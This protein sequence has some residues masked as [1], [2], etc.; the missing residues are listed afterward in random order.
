MAKWTKGVAFKNKDAL[1]ILHMS[2]FIGIFLFLFDA[3]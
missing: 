1:H 2:Q 3:I